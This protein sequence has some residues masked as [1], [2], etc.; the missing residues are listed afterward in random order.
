MNILIK[1]Y[2]NQ[3]TTFLHI[4]KSNYFSFL[5]YFKTS[6]FMKF[7]FIF[8]KAI[9]TNEVSKHNIEFVKLLLSMPNIDIN[10]KSILI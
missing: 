9:L 4:F 8:Q 6:S 3:L 5:L 1:F 2:Y 10:I 7:I